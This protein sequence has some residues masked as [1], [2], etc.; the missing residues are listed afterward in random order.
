MNKWLILTLFLVLKANGLPGQSSVISG[1]VVFEHN[2]KGVDSLVLDLLDSL[3]N[4]LQTALTDS[5]GFYKFSS[6]ENGEYQILAENTGSM[7]VIITEIIT[8][9]GEGKKVNF[10]IPKPC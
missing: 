3:G 5:L 1:Q 2:Q 4:K 6:I 7:D 9:D 8:K 10:E